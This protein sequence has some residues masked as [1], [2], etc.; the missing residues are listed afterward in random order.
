MVCD[1]LSSQDT[2]KHQIWNSYLKEIRRYAP[3]MKRDGRTV[4]LLYASQSSFG[5]IKIS[6]AYANQNSIRI[7][8]REDGYI[9]S[10]DIQLLQGKVSQLEN[11][12]WL[13]NNLIQ[14]LLTPQQNKEH[15]DQKTYEQTR[16][17]SEKNE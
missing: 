11:E 2:F 6:D 4:R 9:S 16:K 17:I 7:Y 8:C 1:T 15:N 14:D 13:A 5:G 3:D 10:R 12:L